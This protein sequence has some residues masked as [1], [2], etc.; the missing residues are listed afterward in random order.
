M[1]NE[2]A[3]DLVFIP[4]RAGDRAA[5]AARLEFALHILPGGRAADELSQ[6]N[7]VEGG[8]AAAADVALV[9]TAFGKVA[10]VSGKTCLLI[11]RFNQAVQTG[12]GT[13][14]LGQGAQMLAEGGHSW[15]EVAGKLG[16][17]ML[18]LMGATIKVC[19]P[20]G[21]QVAVAQNRQAESHQL[22]YVTKSIEELRPGE[23]VLAREEFGPGVELRRIENTFQRTSKT[24]IVLGFTDAHGT[25]HTIRTT[26]EHP[27]WIREQQAFVAARDLVPGMSVAGPNEERQTLQSVNRELYPDSIRVYNLNIGEFHTYFVAASKHDVP[28]LVHNAGAAGECATA[29]KAIVR[30]N[31]WPKHHPFPQYLGG[32]ADQTLKKIP[33]KLHYQFHSSLDKWKNGKYARA[34]T[35]AAFK[36]VDKAEVIRDLTEFYKTADNGAYLKY[37]D[38]FLNAVKESGY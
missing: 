19:F 28:I 11:T 16:E 25:S 3:A 37:L 29:G 36:G 20:A 2:T 38:D 13:Y 12:A 9:L 8:I 26:D 15:D 17:G 31:I 32:A 27:F 1:S 35:A 21:T 33:K 5:E 6:G 18:H 34:K 10:Q 14:R 24:L 30:S 7:Y 23:L 4:V 22:R